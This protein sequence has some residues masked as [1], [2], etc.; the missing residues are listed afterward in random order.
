MTVPDT[1]GGGDVRQPPPLPARRRRWK[2]LLALLAVGFLVYQYFF[3]PRVTVRRVSGASF[4]LYG[5]NRRVEWNSARGRVGYLQLSFDSK[6]S[7]LSDSVTRRR[8]AELLLP[9][10]DSIARRDGDSIIALR[11]MRFPATRML[12]VNIS[13]VTYFHRTSAGGWRQS[14]SLWQ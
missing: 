10:V 12:A 11:H 9:W 1:V 5:L 14:Y 4:E 8:E 6:M 7:G 3:Y 2:A 13:T